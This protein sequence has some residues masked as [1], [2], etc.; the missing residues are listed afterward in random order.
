[1][2]KIDTEKHMDSI[3]NSSKFKK[4]IENLFKGHKNKSHRGSGQ[5]LFNVIIIIIIL[6][7]IIIFIL[8]YY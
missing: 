7:L 4:Y 2:E 5:T 3:I 8:K 6:I 1:M